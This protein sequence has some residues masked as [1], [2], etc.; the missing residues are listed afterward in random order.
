MRPL[1]L[2]ALLAPSSAL[3]ATY[4]VAQDGSGDFETISEAIDAAESGDRI[5]VAAGTY[6]EPVNFDGKDLEVVGVDGSASTII[7]GGGVL[8]AVN[9]LSGETE[10]ALFQGFTVHNDTYRGMLISESSPTIVDVVFEDFALDGLNGGGVFIRNSTAS[11]DSCVFQNNS[12]ESGAHIYMNMGN[13][14]ITNSTF[15]N[16]V[17]ANQ[18]GAIYVDSGSITLESVLLEENESYSNGGAISL[19]SRASLELESSELNDNHSEYGYG[20]GIYTWGSNNVNI[21]SST[22]YGNYPTEYTSGYGGGGLYMAS[23]T[24]NVTDSSFDANYAYYGAAMM[25]YGTTA[26]LENTTFSSNYAYYGGAMYIGSSSTLYDSGCTYDTNTSYYYGGAIYAYYFF[27][28]T[29]DGTVFNEN[30]AYYGYGGAIFSSDYGSMELNEVE[31]TTNYAYYAG[32]AVYAYNYQSD[33]FINSSTFTENTATYSHGGALYSYYLTNV[34]V[35]DST[36]EY[37]EAYGSGGALYNYYYSGLAVTNSDFTYNV[38]TYTSGGAV[39]FNPYVAGYDLTFVG[40]DVKGNASRYEGGGL[41][42]AGGTS[43]TIQGNTFLQNV[44]EDDSFG[45]GIIASGYQDLTL[46][47]NVIAGNE[48]IIGGGVYLGEGY[49]ETAT[50]WIV[51]NALADNEAN[52]LGGALAAVSQGGITLQ[53]NTIVGN[54]AAQGG[55]GLYLYESPADVRNNILA[56]T[57]DGDAI[58]LSGTD[59]LAVSSVQYNDLYDNPAGDLGGDLAT[60]GIDDTNLTTDPRLAG[61]TLDGEH[62][63]DSYALSLAS[64]CIDAGDPELSDLDGTRSDMGMYGGPYAFLSDD[65]TDGYSS[66]YDCDDS[67]ATIY[68]GASETWYDGTD[69]DCS[70]TSDYDQD[71]DG[72][73]SISGEGD[74]CD[75]SDPSVIECPTETGDTGPTDTSTPDTSDPDTADP[76]TADPDSEPS[77]TGSPETGK[78]EGGGGCSCTAAPTRP[79]LPAALALLALAA[80]RRRRAV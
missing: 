30:A 43:H 29:F 80:V 72:H 79:A 75:D 60:L 40:N 61:Y 5:E 31:F 69:A 68:P 21:E 13:V 22:F 18:G 55:G 57:I 73:D 76:D 67:D 42:I 23:G 53:N 50:A 71:G 64:P 74:D 36:F 38:A 3:A 19:N 34:N 62:D 66:A 41:Y 17:A 52:R 33:L 48:A 58:T 49:D 16:G 39:Y 26:T 2:L 65:D 9:F 47:G 63:N 4:T 56:R 11:F 28:L 25:L 32:G 12:G 14:T 45:G 59:A 44:L 35:A 10:D 37:N 20:A 46:W 15:T 7:E 51:N 78:V 8:A 27:D 77:E 70:G 1:V 6:E 24:L 54:Q